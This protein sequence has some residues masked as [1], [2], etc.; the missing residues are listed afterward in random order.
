MVCKVR[1]DGRYELQSR[2]SETEDRDEGAKRLLARDV[3]PDIWAGQAVYDRRSLAIY[4][5]LVLGLSNRWIWRCPTGRLLDLYRRHVSAKHLD[6][7]VGTGYFLDRCGFPVAEPRI[8]LIDLNPTC[9]AVAAKRIARYQ[10][11][12]H[13]ANLLAPLTGVPGGFDSVSLTYLLHCLPGGMA[14]KAAVLDH[15][16]PLMNPGATIFGA[17]LLSEG[18][19]RSALARGLAR[20]YNRKGVFGNAEDSLV[21]LEAALTA[22]FEVLELETV[23]CA[24][25]FVAKV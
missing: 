2:G 23:G 14:E 4:D 8:A 16:R 18:V 24:A 25:L 6:L 20:L 12:Q 17:T 19:P 7:G 3:D 9:L 21:G 1:D 10:P 22:R 11:E 15:L 13:R 5:V